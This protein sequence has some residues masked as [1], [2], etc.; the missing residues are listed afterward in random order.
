MNMRFMSKFDLQLRVQLSNCQMHVFLKHF[1]R[2]HTFFQMNKVYNRVG[3]RS[4]DSQKS[5]NWTKFSPLENKMRQKEKFSMQKNDWLS[6]CVILWFFFC[7]LMT[8]SGIFLEALQDLI[9]FEW[10]GL[11]P[12]VTILKWI[13]WILIWANVKMSTLKVEIFM[14]NLNF[15]VLNFEF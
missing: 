4:V 14:L 13:C 9:F 2:H 8:L 11:A 6:Q 3:S 1:F 12:E 5:S 10:L 7:H 15:V